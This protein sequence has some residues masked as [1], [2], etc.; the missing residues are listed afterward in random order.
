MSNNEKT[1]RSTRDLNEDIEK[2]KQHQELGYDRI[3]KYYKF[4]NVEEKND[5]L[6]KMQDLEK[7]PHKHLFEDAVDLLERT[8]AVRES[9]RS[10]IDDRSAW[11]RE[12]YIQLAIVTESLLNAI[13]LKHDREYFFNKSL[14]YQSPGFNE[15]M[16]KTMGILSNHGL[17]NQAKKR[18]CS[19]LYLLKQHRDN[20]IHLNFHRT[21]HANHPPRIYETLAFM[22]SCFFDQEHDLKH[23][24]L[25]LTSE[26]DDGNVGLNYPKVDLPMD[27]VIEPEA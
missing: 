21:S 10:I 25:E 23:H 19:V 26:K 12:H 17:N 4:G 16:G 20:R 27:K 8:V 13:V 9:D 1:P 22:I 18:V 3:K 6:D 15:L 5:R 14:P 7:P 24:L 2:I 11:D